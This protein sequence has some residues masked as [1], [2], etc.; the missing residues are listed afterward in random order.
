M[1]VDCPSS[2]LS[3]S[4]LV[5]TTEGLSF[6]TF[7]NGCLVWIEPDSESSLVMLGKGILR[8]CLLLVSTLQLSKRNV[9]AMRARVMGEY[10]VKICRDPSRSCEEKQGVRE[11]WSLRR[12]QR[13][14]ACEE[15]P[16]V[17]KLLPCSKAPLLLLLGYWHPKVLSCMTFFVQQNKLLHNQGYYACQSFTSSNY[18]PLHL[19]P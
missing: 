1:L 15:Q 5:T 7:P 3:I 2:C 13:L 6:V 18:L 8:L 11:L 9:G 17:S 14:C 4:A 10:C 12:L 19:L 16:G